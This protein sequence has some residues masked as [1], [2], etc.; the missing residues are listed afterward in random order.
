MW[1]SFS[2]D[3]KKLISYRIQMSIRRGDTWNRQVNNRKWLV[4]GI[5]A[6]LCESRNLFY[7]NVERREWTSLMI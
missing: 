2:T 3:V 1:K 6:Y 4:L 7:G 5:N